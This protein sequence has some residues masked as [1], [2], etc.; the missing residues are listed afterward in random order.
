MEKS[1]KDYR[2]GIKSGV[3]SGLA[4]GILYSLLMIFS[5]VVNL[6]MVEDLANQFLDYGMGKSFFY[7]LYFVLMP[8]FLIGFS[9]VAGIIFG[10]CFVWLIN[11]LPSSKV[12]IKSLILSLI[13]WIF[14]PIP[15]GLLIVLQAPDSKI[16]MILYSLFSY[17]AFGLI[18]SLIYNKISLKSK[19][20]N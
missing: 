14:V 4:Y 13:F 19:K 18:F 5:L 11:K 6:R 20:H 3:L 10:V 7:L 17:L 8:I 2:L 12:L 9:I 1:T 16:I 15:F